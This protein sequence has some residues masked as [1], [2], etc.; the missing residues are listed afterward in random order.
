MERT[1]SDMAKFAGGAA[2]GGGLLVWLGAEVGNSAKIVYVYLDGRF[3]AALF[4][5]EDVHHDGAVRAFRAIARKGYKAV[6]SRLAVMEAVAIV[7]KKAARS[8]RCRSESAEELAGVEAH[9]QDAAGGMSAFVDKMV[10]GKKL[11]I[12]D[13]KGLSPDLELLY[14]K[15]HEHSGRIVP[16]PE[17]D[18]CRHIGV[19]SCDWVGIWLAR[20]FGAAVICTTDTA[21]ADIPGRDDEVG[22][23]AV[24]LASAPLAGPLA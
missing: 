2:R 19:G 8:Y 23:I 18:E 17:G 21:L 5:L 11:R 9:V 20:A 10:E 24:Q 6:T 15:V 12:M 3:L 13:S 22:G 14:G 1:A 4:D 16:A 7:R